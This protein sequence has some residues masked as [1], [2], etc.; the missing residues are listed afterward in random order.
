M[1]EAVKNLITREKRFSFALKLLY[2]GAAVFFIG[3]IIALFAFPSVNQ[4]L[5]LYLFLGGIALFLSLIYLL[6]V[7]LL[8]THRE[9]AASYQQKFDIE[10]LVNFEMSAQYFKDA[11]FL[12]YED[13]NVIIANKLLLQENKGLVK[14]DYLIQ[15]VATLN[16]MSLEDY[17]AT[18]GK[19][20]SKYLKE[21]EKMVSVTKNKIITVGAF[22]HYVQEVPEE[23]A[24][25]FK[26]QAQ[27]RYLLR[28]DIIVDEANKQLHYPSHIE[29]YKDRR[30][31]GQLFPAPYNEIADFVRKT[32]L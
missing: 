27:Q 3:E 26:V 2:A 9:I 21:F 28:L 32:Y 4:D 13:E 18:H 5:I 14:R 23:L 25:E 7:N 29:T 10:Q 11:G 12:V 6:V 22:I 20:M 1:T 16:E 31:C 17:M 24:R 30:W 15:I 8:T 19:T